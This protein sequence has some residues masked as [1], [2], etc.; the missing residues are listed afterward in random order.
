M[1]HRLS[2]STRHDYDTRKVGITVPVW[3]RSGENIINLE[4]KLDTGASCCIFRRALGQILGLDVESG[5]RREMSTVTG[6]FSVFGHEVTLTVL[7]IE[8]DTT[9]FFAASEHFNRDVLGREGWLDRVRVGLIDY[10]GSLYLNR[11]DAE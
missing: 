6:S 5:S 1:Q 2:F 8:I 10:D 11:Y 9:V 3:L 7:G 4:A